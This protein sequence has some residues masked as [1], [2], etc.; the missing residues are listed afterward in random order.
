MLNKS[1]HLALSHRIVLCCVFVVSISIGNLSLMKYGCLSLEKLSKKYQD[2]K[3][4]TVLIV[5]SLVADWSHSTFWASF[6]I[7]KKNIKIWWDLCILFDLY[8]CIFRTGWFSSSTLFIGSFGM[9]FKFLN[10]S[11]ILLRHCTQLWR[12]KIYD[13]FMS[14][15]MNHILVM[16]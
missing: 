16:N 6:W 13:K 3:A 1:Y 7:Q 11:F 8:N 15:L 5:M 2:V 10:C 12:T 14:W 4:L 9:H